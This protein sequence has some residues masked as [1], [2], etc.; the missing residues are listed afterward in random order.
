[1]RGCGDMGHRLQERNAAQEKVTREVKVGL[2][3]VGTWG[4]MGT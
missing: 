4:G 3:A 2:V 1:M